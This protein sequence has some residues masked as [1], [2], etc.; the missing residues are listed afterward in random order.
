M[1]RS[2]LI[3]E[4]GALSYPYLVCQTLLTPHGIPYSLIGVDGGGLEEKQGGRKR[5]GGRT[6]VGV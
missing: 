3:Q 4:G 6:V 5:V 1:L 2:V